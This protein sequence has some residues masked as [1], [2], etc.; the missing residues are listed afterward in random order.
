MVHFAQSED[1]RRSPCET[2][3]YVAGTEISFTAQKQR[4]LRGKRDTAQRG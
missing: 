3:R 2:E 1:I 4:A